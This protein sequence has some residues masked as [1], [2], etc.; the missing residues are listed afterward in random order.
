MNPINILGLEEKI[1]PFEGQ[2]IK[3]IAFQKLTLGTATKFYSKD[4][5]DYKFSIGATGE[6]EIELFNSIEDE[7]E[8]GVIG[9]IISLSE[10]QSYLKY[11]AAGNAKFT[12][13]QAS[14]GIDLKLLSKRSA[15]F[16]VYKTHALSEEFCKAIEKDL[17]NFVSVLNIGDTNETLAVGE[18]AAF[19]VNGQ[20]EAKISLAYSDIYLS[21][22]NALSKLLDKNELLKIQ[23]KPDLTLDF[24]VNISDTFTVVFHRNT[25]QQYTVLVKKADVKQF[26]GGVKAGIWID[27]PDT[28]Q[29][30][31]IVGDL[32]E[33]LLEASETKIQAILKKS[34]VAD[35][36]RT[37][38]VLLESLQD[39]LGLDQATDKL[40]ALKGKYTEFRKKAEET[41]E[42]IAKA[43]VELGINYEYQRI[44]TRKLLF[45]GKF[46]RAAIR[47]YHFNLLTGDLKKIVE[48]H[49]NGNPDNIRVEHY[50]QES[51]KKR[52]KAWGFSLG[53]AST[54]S[55]Q[56]IEEVERKDIH[57]HKQVAFAAY[58][59][60]KNKFLGNETSWGVD[61][62]VAMP[63]FSASETPLASEFDYSLYLKMEWKDKKLR[64]KEDLLAYL[65]QG[66]LWKAIPQ[67]EMMAIADDF[68]PKM[69]KDTLTV[70]SQLKVSPFAFREI[71]NRMVLYNLRN[72][73]L[74]NFLG[75]AMPYDQ[76]E[77]IRRNVELRSKYYGQVWT[78]Y[79]NN[80]IK[81]NEDYFITF[82]YNTL[83]P[84][85]PALARRERRPNKTK[86]EETVWL[87]NNTDDHLNRFKK[88]I[89]RLH[90]GISQPTPYSEVIKDSYKEIQAFWLKPFY[91]RAFGAYLLYAASQATSVLDEIERIFTI[92]YQSEE[93]KE[94]IVNL[95]TSI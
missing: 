53:F 55:E 40:G 43:S 80:P 34:K 6:F 38:L 73:I 17:S 54:K 69:K 66:V 65:D 76:D 11:I 15:L 27:L 14:K 48:N 3:D 52:K 22:L 62:N 46:T 29:L 84:V 63:V 13:T 67:G 10:D 7:D 51:E 30:K 75:A 93:G 35:L 21:S 25:A 18:A 4:V 91:T 83:K 87:N 58:R 44:S 42:E 19:H 82:T 79:L 39:R 70:T 1:R 49:Q 86:R 92:S 89:Q 74:G 64:K 77:D 32:L 37:Q 56:E 90:S 71:L 88:G 33:N 24:T 59:E 72:E 60:Y 26:G 9:D 2:Q 61:F 45:K 16:T 57:G 36:S 50:L 20:L 78:H 85:S 81:G 95:T 41:I 12:G 68:F 23:F 28:K 31:L 94:E 47:K 5:K 8:H